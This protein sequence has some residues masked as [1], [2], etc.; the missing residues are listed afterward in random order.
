MI[1]NT[2]SVTFNVK[3]LSQMLHFYCDILGM[4]QKYTINHRAKPEARAT[5]LDDEPWLVCLEFAD[6]QCLELC[7]PGGPLDAAPKVQD[8]YGYQKVC[9]EVDDAAA[10]HAELVGSGVVPDTEVRMTADF[11]WAFNL[12]D[13]EG[14]RLEIVQYTDRSPQVRQDWQEVDR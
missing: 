9:L 4:K 8:H 3:D 14:N 12:T 10:A 11:A 1:V 2:G 6:R 5:H 13:P 7:N